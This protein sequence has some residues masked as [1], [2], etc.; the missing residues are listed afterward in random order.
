MS[1]FIRFDQVSY[2][3]SII[4]LELRINYIRIVL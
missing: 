3:D 1:N 2:Y 4:D